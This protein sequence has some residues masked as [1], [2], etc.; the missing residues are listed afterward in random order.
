MSTMTNFSCE[1]SNID[2]L[3]KIC[4]SMLRSISTF[5]QLDLVNK[6]RTSMSESI[7]NTKSTYF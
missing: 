3:L 4:T 1:K 2:V 5:N 7:L 6:K